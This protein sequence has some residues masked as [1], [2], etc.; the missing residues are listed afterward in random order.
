V[1]YSSTNPPNAFTDVLAFSMALGTLLSS[2]TT[3]QNMDT[4]KPLIGTRKPTPFLHTGISIPPHIMKSLF[5]C[6]V[7]HSTNQHAPTAG[8]KLNTQSSGRDLVKMVLLLLPQANAFP[9]TPAKLLAPIRTPSV[10][11]GLAGIPMSARKIHG[12]WRNFVP[13]VVEF[14]RRKKRMNCK[15]KY[16]II[17][18]KGSVPLSGVEKSLAR[19]RTFDAVRNRIGQQSTSASPCQTFRHSHFIS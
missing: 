6:S 8:V 19:S 13:K 2:S 12:T 18:I 11:N 1:I 4:E 16:L 17:N 3:T 14:V 7:L 10:P 15:T 9:L 5:G